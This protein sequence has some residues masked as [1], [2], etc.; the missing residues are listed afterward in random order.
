VCLKLKII[1]PKFVTVKQ[2]RKMGLPRPSTSE[3][4]PV[5]ASLKKELGTK[6]ECW[7][8]QSSGSA[9]SPFTPSIVLF[10][11]EYVFQSEK[12]VELMGRRGYL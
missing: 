6:T 11:M 4:A 3:L 2:K 12:D 9:E 1:H 10:E 7:K 5:L 8:K